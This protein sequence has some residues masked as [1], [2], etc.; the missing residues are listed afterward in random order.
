VIKLQVCRH[1][2]AGVPHWDQWSVK[3]QAVNDQCW[4]DRHG[5]QAAD[6]A[7]RD[8]PTSPSPVK[9]TCHSAL[10]VKQIS[11][12]F[13]LALSPTSTPLLWRQLLHTMSLA[14]LNPNNIQQMQKQQQVASS[15]SRR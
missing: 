13:L 15:S 1:H 2:N 8:R 11:S 5:W 3:S 6:L 4:E 14:L 10:T 9:H 7:H 12:S